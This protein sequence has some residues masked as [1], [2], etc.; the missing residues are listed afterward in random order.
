MSREEMQ[1]FSLLLSLAGRIERQIELCK[2]G[3][4]WYDAGCQVILEY[5]RLLE[6]CRVSE[7]ITTPG[8]DFDGIVEPVTHS[9]E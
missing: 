7:S 3:L 8:Y 2:Q 9:M 4:S 5:N 1:A 6:I